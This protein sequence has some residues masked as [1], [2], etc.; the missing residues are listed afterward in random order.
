MVTASLRV[1]EQ[2]VDNQYG[3]HDKTKFGIMYDTPVS[4][5]DSCIDFICDNIF[6]ICDTQVS[7]DQVPRLL[8]K[9]EETYLHSDIAEQLLFTLSERGKIDD[10]TLTFFDSRVT[11]LRNVRLRNASRLTQKGLRTLRPHHITHLE[12]SGLTLVTVNDLIGCL[13]EWTLQNLRTLNVANSTFIN[14]VKYCVVVSLSKLRNLHT[15]NVSNTEFNRHGLE[16]VA[17][18]LV[19]LEHLDISGTRVSDIAPLRKCRNRLKSLNM[20]NIFSSSRD[21]V[22]SIICELHQLRHLDISDDRDE[23]P[24]ERLSQ[25]RCRISELLQRHTCLPHLKSLD[26]SGK[27]GIELVDL[28]KFLSGHPKM[29]FL[30]L[31]QTN[32][33]CDSMFTDS[34][35]VLY[36]KNLTVTGSGNENQIL[37]ALRRYPYRVLY[38]LKSLY[39]LFPLTQTYAE[40]RLDVLKMI[41]PGMKAHP[42]QLGIQMG[43]TACLYNLCKGEYGQKIHPHLLKVIVELTLTAMESFPTHA[44]LQKNTLLTLCSDR[45]LQEVTFDKFRCA[46]LVMDCLCMFDDSSMNRMCVA[47][48]SILAAKISTSET[49]SL[50]AKPCYMK[51]LL[52]IVRSKMDEGV[53]DITMKFTLSALWNLTDESPQTCGVFLNEGG[54]E[55]FLDVI[56]TFQTKSAVETKVL[57]LMNNIAEVKEL[58]PA[59]MMENFIV[60]LRSLLKSS[61]IDVSY[62]AAGIIAHLA[63]DGACNWTVT[64]IS[65]DDVLR[66][67]AE[68][69]LNWV[70]PEGEMVAYRSFSPFFPLLTCYETKEVQLWAV[71]AVHHVC[72]KNTKRYCPMLLEEGGVKLLVELLSSLQ[73]SNEVKEICLKIMDV[74]RREGNVFNYQ[75]PPMEECVTMC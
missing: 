22:I 25:F 62:F 19:M 75:I 64:T 48:C 57:G 12:A 27:E 49:S 74:L 5:Q 21:E 9:D 71:W 43:A 17:E 23:H 32:V 31:V 52:S 6:A 20:Y 45:I 11:R 35:H 29:Y 38:T 58:R 40:L 67:L 47:I 10:T 68:A 33:C 41:L 3:C 69:V 24:F 61:H 1:Q 54:L 14:N 8:L 18:D 2:G 53:V 59:L 37:E 36:N 72:T 66:D 28:R 46:R 51:K 16:I 7:E 56:E 34:L 42:K 13:G 44:Q 4:L 50:G 26:I 15:L 65:R 55:L 73:I 60:G 39:Y 63:S 30:G 70:T